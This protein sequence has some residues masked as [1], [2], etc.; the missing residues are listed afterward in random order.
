MIE[1]T[2]LNINLPRY[3]YIVKVRLN[4]SPLSNVKPTEIGQFDNFSEASKL[5]NDVPGSWIENK[6][7]SN[8]NHNKQV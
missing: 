2:E 7:V 4:A 3:F 5:C 1:H 6:K 8:N